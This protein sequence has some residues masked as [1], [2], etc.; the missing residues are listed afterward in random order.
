MSQVCYFLNKPVVYLDNKTFNICSLFITNSMTLLM[1]SH[2][3]IPKI[4]C[5]Y[6]H[7]ITNLPTLTVPLSTL[8]LR[9]LLTGCS[10]WKMK[11][12]EKYFFTELGA[13]DKFSNC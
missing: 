5:T 8:A 6:M 2:F 9:L 4:V 11:H 1:H 3:L 13:E 12:L 7:T 10:N